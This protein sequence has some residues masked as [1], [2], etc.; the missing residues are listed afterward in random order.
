MVVCL[1]WPSGEGGEGAEEGCASVGVKG[2][3]KETK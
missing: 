3:V 2:R 1:D